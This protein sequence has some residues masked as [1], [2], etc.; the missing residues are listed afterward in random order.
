MAG[1][2]HVYAVS[3][4]GDVTVFKAADE[5]E[6]VATNRMHEPCLATPALVD[7][8]IIL[9]TQQQLICI[10]SSTVAVTAPVATPEAST[11]AARSPADLDTSTST[12]S[13]QP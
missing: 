3:E 2:D 7:G 4:R 12:L 10:G 9:R 6:L 11:T 8:E 5:F 1:G 13:T